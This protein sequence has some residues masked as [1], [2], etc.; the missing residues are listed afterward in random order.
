MS[1]SRIIG[2][3]IVAIMVIVGGLRLAGAQVAAIAVGTLVVPGMGVVFALTALVTSIVRGRSTSDGK[4]DFSSFDP[5]EE[6]MFVVH[7]QWMRKNGQRAGRMGLAAAG[8][9]SA[10]AALIIMTCYTPCSKFCERPPSPCKTDQEQKK[11]RETCEETCSVAKKQQGKEFVEGLTGCS[12]A[13]SVSGPC[14][15][16]TK[17]AITMGLWCEAKD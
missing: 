10:L 7:E 16:L 12:F 17:K 6:G 5:A 13:N 8:G 14:E 11:F 3:V 15:G 4:K 1:F 9:A 2:I